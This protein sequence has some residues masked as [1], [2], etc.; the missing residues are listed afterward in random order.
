MPESG[1]VEVSVDRGVASIEFFHPR[2]NSLPG[3]LLARLAETVA[4]LGREPAVRVLVLRSGGAGPFCAG[5]SFEELTAID[6]PAR[7]KEFFMGFARLILAIK[8]CPKFVVARVHGKAVGGGVGLVAAADYA[9]A[10]E[11]ASVKLSELAL[12]IGPFVVGPCVEKKI[13]FGPFAA[14]SID[15]AWRDAQWAKTHGLYADVFT[16]LEELDTGVRRLTR[17]LADSS[18]E[19]MALLKHAFWRGSEDWDRLLEERAAF[20]GKLVLSE[21]TSRAIAGFGA[22]EPGGKV[23]SPN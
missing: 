22:S 19:A 12:G 8:D 14:M 15:T 23:P 4:D 5:A 16:T 21:F 17:R 10:V 13:G 6:S 3:T 2:K 11:Q 9:L 7:G 20:S 1:T 18:P